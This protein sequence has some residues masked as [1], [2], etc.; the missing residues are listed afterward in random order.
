VVGSPQ[1]SNSLRL[2]EV[3]E[4]SGCPIAVLIERAAQIPWQRL[5][6]IATVGVTA[7]AS[8]PEVIVDEVIEAFRSRFDVTVDVVTTA[9]ERVVFNVPRELR[10]RVAS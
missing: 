2:V 9:E 7:G 4:R 10:Q 3:A 6:G 8:A 1:S 5:G